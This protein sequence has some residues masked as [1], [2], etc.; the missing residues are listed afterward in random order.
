M[1]VLTTGIFPSATFQVT[2]SQVST[3]Q[4]F[5]FPSGN[6]LKVRLPIPVGR[7]LRL[8][9]ARGRALRLE[10][11]RGRALRLEWA[12]GRGLGLGQTWEVSAWKILFRKVPRILDVIF[13]LL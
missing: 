4:M 12:R 6:L 11:A 3:S 13:L 2:I 9:W 10:W 5:H 1:N 8:E 7:A